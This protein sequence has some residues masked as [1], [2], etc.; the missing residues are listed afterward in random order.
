MLFFNLIPFHITMPI[1]LSNLNAVGPPRSSKK[2]HESGKG[3]TIKLPI[4]TYDLSHKFALFSHSAFFFFFRTIASM[5]GWKKKRSVKSFFCVCF[6][7]FRKVGLY[8]KIEFL[9]FTNNFFCELT[10]YI[11]IHLNIPNGH[12]GLLERYYS[13]LY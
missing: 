11:I 10:K 5:E 1:H 2:K 3:H 4:G 6:T 12:C 8:A 7:A 13:F 9:H